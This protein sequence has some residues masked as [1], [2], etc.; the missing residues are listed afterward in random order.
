[1]RRMG[2]RRFEFSRALRRALSRE[3]HEN[4]GTLTSAKTIPPLFTVTDK[5]TGRLAG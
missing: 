4:G 1:M 2:T 3:R 5:W